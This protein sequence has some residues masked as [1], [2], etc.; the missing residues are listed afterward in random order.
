MNNKQTKFQ[1]GIKIYRRISLLVGLVF[2][3]AI[4]VFSWMVKS[5]MDVGQHPTRPS[6]SVSSVAVE[7]QTTEETTEATQNTEGV[8]GSD[9]VFQEKGKG[10]LYEYTLDG[11]TISVVEVDGL[12]LEIVGWGD[13]KPEE[14]DKILN[15]PLTDK[16][17]ISEWTVE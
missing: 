17:Y 14:F 9:G 3:A 1:K 11:K 10:Y 15:S 8:M 4:L 6:T 13:V 7:E 5:G 12:P 16:K 2:T